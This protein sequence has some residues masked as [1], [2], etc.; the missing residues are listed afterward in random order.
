MNK[1]Q[2]QEAKD[3][4]AHSNFRKGLSDYNDGENVTHQLGNDDYKNGNNLDDPYPENE[5]FDGTVAAGNDL[6]P[7]EDQDET[8]EE[9]DLRYE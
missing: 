6:P 9:Q 8:D 3:R 4:N 1:S 2:G 7:D 5:N